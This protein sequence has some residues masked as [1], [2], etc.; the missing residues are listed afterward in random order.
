M[1]GWEATFNFSLHW[2]GRCLGV[3]L[4][5]AS[6]LKAWPGKWLP[7]HRPNNGPW[8]KQVVQVPGA[9][10]EPE[11]FPKISGR[12]E[13]EPGTRDRGGHG[14]AVEPWVRNMMGASTSWSLAPGTSVRWEAAQ[15]IL[16]F[17]LG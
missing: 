13:E 2:Q 3:A 12:Q 14:S 10:Q 1:R 15:W 17:L 8:T 9:N 11:A 5:L 16:W 6:V 7:H 4:A